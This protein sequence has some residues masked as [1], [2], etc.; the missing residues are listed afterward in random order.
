MRF[1]NATQVRVLD[2][3]FNHAG[4][5]GFFR[6]FVFENFAEFAMNWFISDQDILNMQRSIRSE[7]HE[8]LA[9]ARMGAAEP[10]SEGGLNPRPVE[11]N[12]SPQRDQLVR[13]NREVKHRLVR[14]WR[15]TPATGR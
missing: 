3:L 8:G 9:G 6:T 10:G 11:R 4:H 2:D 13:K 5:P 12:G 15:A 7:F 1:R 14:W